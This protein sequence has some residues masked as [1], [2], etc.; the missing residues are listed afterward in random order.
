MYFH[1]QLP[2]S[3]KLTSWLCLDGLTQRIKEP[4]PGRP[5]A[6]RPLG[7]PCMGSPAR[8]LLAWGLCSSL[9]APGKPFE[10]AS[11]PSACLPSHLAKERLQP[12]KP[13]NHLRQGWNIQLVPFW[14]RAACSLFSHYLH[15]RHVSSGCSPWQTSLI[16]HTTLCNKTQAWGGVTRWRLRRWS[17]ISWRVHSVN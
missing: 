11:W 10:E 15:S 17:F 13:Y 3:L 14:T 9:Q 4:M 16:K 1:L 8:F 6:C 5:A 7:G 2:N 12:G